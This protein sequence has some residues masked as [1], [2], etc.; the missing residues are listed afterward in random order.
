MIHLNE[1]TRALTANAET[2]RALL[3]TVPPEQGAW[4][5]G[6]EI[7]SLHAVMQHM[8]NEE[9]L[10][11]RMH[12]REMFSDPPQ[13]WG[14]IR[15]EEREAGAKTVPDLAAAL[16][17]FLRERAESVTWLRGL[18]T[19]D[20]ELISRPPW[21]A[22]KAGDVLVSWVEHD[23]LHMRQLIEILYAL[24]VK[25]AEPYSVQYAGDW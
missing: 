19:P 8:Y 7:W 25:L 1:T 23:F 12:L 3:Q 2:F 17:G 10:D 11:F 22:I 5:P 4:K 13:P 21:G 14:L 18:E 9:R 20:W 6:P 16:E 24:N 15:E